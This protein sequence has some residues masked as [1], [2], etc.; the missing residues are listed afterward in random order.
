[1][2]LQVYLA[3]VLASVVVLIVPGPT[4]T[5][6]IANSLRYGARAGL[7]NIAGTQIGLAM[8]L[9][10]LLLG[11]ETVMAL[12]GQWFDWVRMA[13]ALYLVW[14]GV[15]MAMAKAPPAV[16]TGPG[17]AAAP[18]R[19]TGLP[20]G[21]VLQGLAVVLSNPKVLLFFGAFIPQFV[22]TSRASAP[23]VL[24]LAL[25]FMVLATLMDSGY[26]LLAGRAGG[27]LAGRWQLMLERASGVILICGGIWLALLRR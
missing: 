9:G 16:G 12:M 14:I 24:L 27:A 8:M 19:T 18:T 7:L 20:K 6:I 26:A 3:Y 15:R 4:V 13:G 25:T 1:M 11:L 17:E 23:Q 2:T 21:F 10:V 22:D 5:L